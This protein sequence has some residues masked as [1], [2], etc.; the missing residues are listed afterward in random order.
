MIIYVRIVRKNF[1]VY[2]G[3]DNYYKILNQIDSILTK[4]EAFITNKIHI[5][6]MSHGHRTLEDRIAE[7]DEDYQRA[8]RSAVAWA[9]RNMDDGPEDI[10]AAR[11]QNVHEGEASDPDNYF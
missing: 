2:S 11:E 1:D 8:K 7:S 4:R 3:L 6:C 9:Y 5:L 10:H